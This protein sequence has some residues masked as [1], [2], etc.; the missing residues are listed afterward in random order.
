MNTDTN[1]D[2]TILAIS[3]STAHCS[4]AILR[5]NK[6][7]A[8]KEW[9]SKMINNHEVFKAIPALFSDAAISINDITSFAVD[10]GPGSFAGIRTAIS[11][12][13]GMALPDKQKVTG[14]SCGEAIACEILKNNPDKT[15]VVVGD[16]RRQSL[17][18]AEFILKNDTLTTSQDYS[19]TTKDE[20]PTLIK[21]ETI[22]ATP[23]WHRLEEYLT[24]TT[25]KNS[26]LIS[27]QS[28]PTAETIAFLA[29][30]NHARPALPLYMHPPVA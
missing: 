22:I 28:F 20:F 29:I 7:M 10:I 16:A 13:N 14:I 5:N 24:T 17:W 8:Q 2:S 19:L 27:Q 23:D 12:I 21:K 3:Q 25:P 26:T 11:T 15:I 4:C 9:D 1:T 6:L 30:S 18:Y